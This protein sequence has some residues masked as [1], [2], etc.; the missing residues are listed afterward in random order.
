ME[1][2]RISI[3]TTA[4]FGLGMATAAHAATINYVGSVTNGEATHW[5]STSTAKTMDLDGDNKYGT[6]AALLFRSGFAGQQSSPT[7]TTLGVYFSGSGTQPTSNLSSYSLIDNLNGTGTVHAGI[8]LY[9]TATNPTYP[10]FVFQL[11]GTAADYAGKVLRIG[12]MEDVLGS[13]EWA[14]DA[15]KGL[16]MTQSIGG[17][18]DSGAISLRSGGA[19]DGVPEIYF[20]DIYGATVGDQFA[21][22]GLSNVGGTPTG[23]NPYIS[24]VSF[25]LATVA[26]PAPAALEGGLVL[27]G[28]IAGTRRRN[29]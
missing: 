15:H 26:V 6:M 19:G 16:Q 5:R 8:A 10:D 12:V 9:G 1:P 4:L 29:R 7:S 28:I 2:T 14:A 23:Q 24:S 27:L 25:D 18:G 21:I 17:S 3:L 20:F 22:T 13:S 11:T